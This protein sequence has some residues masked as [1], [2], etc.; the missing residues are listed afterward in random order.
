M[1][2]TIYA[3]NINYGDWVWYFDNGHQLV[4]LMFL[5]IVAAPSLGLGS[6][7]IFHFLCWSWGLV[8]LC[9][10][11]DGG[12]LHGHEGKNSFGFTVIR[13][14]KI[15]AFMCYPTSHLVCGWLQVL[16]SVESVMIQSSLLVLV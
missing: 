11:E 15:D 6:R 13:W 7:W 10:R 16:G 14:F 3:T 9:T 8:L 12:D 4:H 2:V 5:V 1:E